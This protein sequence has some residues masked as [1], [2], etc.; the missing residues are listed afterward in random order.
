MANK[1]FGSLI[2]LFGLVCLGFCLH[3]VSQEVLLD[4]TGRSTTG[5]VT[6]K[7]TSEDENH[8]VSD[9]LSYSYQDSSGN[10][11]TSNSDVFASMFNSATRGSPIPVVY[12]SAYPSISRIRSAG[13][14][15]LPGGMFALMAGCLLW[16]GLR[17]LLRQIYW[18]NKLA[19]L[20]TSGE[21]RT[22]RLVALEED[23]AEAADGDSPLVLVYAFTDK[24]GQERTGK[25]AHVRPRDHDFWKGRIGCPL[26]V[27]VNP[28]DHADHIALVE[29]SKLLGCGERGL[30][31]SP[32]GN[33]GERHQL[34]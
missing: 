34:D 10:T 18:D 25:T 5:T 29:E 26:D 9:Y 3:Y 8:S 27:R 13:E 20:T 19:R 15:F 11:H 23:K 6:D 31:I 7:T 1:I 12:S 32:K 17:T 30:P 33:R 16:F 2:V 14:G 22:G 4:V 21:R 28:T 24:T